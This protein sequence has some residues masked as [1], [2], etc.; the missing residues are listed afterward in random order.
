MLT[1]AKKQELSQ[2]V[3]QQWTNG[4][5]KLYQAIEKVVATVADEDKQEAQNHLAKVYARFFDAKYD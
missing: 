2:A 3:G 5:L 1:K 4:G